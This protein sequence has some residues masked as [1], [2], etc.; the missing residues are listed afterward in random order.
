MAPP[1]FVGGRGVDFVRAMRK[2]PQLRW[3][4]MLVVRWEDFWPSSAEEAGPDLGPLAAR[5]SPL[6]DQD[7]EMAR[8]VE[9]EIDRLIDC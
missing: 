6:I 7:L 2:D 9:D 4:S 3:A 1:F 5:L 8:R